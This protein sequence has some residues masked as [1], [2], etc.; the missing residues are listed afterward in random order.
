MP[1]CPPARNPQS[2]GEA[3]LRSGLHLIAD[4]LSSEWHSHRRRRF[5]D[6]T[7]SSLQ[8]TLAGVCTF[9]SKKVTIYDLPLFDFIKPYAPRREVRVI[10]TTNLDAA[11]RDVI[12][13]GTAWRLACTAFAEICGPPVM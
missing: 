1:H 7:T 5:D 6:R 3:R 12:R 11:L 10:R 9:I 13:D 8:H 4:D 2:I